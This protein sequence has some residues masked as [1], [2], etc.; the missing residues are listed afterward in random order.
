MESSVS[1][2]GSLVH[3]HLQNPFHKAGDGVLRLGAGE[4]NDVHV[5]AYPVQRLGGVHRVNDS[6]DDVLDQVEAY[7]G[8]IGGLLNELFGLRISSRVGI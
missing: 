6:P 4:G 2:Q 1:G 7:P 3:F 8:S 5:A